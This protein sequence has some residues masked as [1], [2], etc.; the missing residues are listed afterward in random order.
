MTIKP[1]CTFLP[2]EHSAPHPTT[3]EPTV[4]DEL[5]AEVLRKK[6]RRE[7]IRNIVRKVQLAE[8]PNTGSS[9]GGTSSTTD[10]LNSLPALP[11]FFCPIVMRN[12]M[13]AWQRDFFSKV[14]AEARRIAERRI[15]EGWP[16][17]LV[18]KGESLNEA[19]SLITCNPFEAGYHAAMARSAFETNLESLLLEKNAGG[20]AARFAR[21][22][23]TQ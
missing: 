11:L 5:L 7:R 15:A 6:S 9:P 17:T 12:E 16:D 10:A 4:N 1:T 14:T 2:D 20:C 8:E 19:L 18:T 13:D 3:N 21:A 22:H 23:C